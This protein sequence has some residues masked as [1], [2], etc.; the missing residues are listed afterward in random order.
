MVAVT[1][2]LLLGAP[3]A[4]THEG[5]AF[6]C[7]AFGDIPY[8]VTHSPTHVR[9]LAW[10]EFHC[11]SA[12]TLSVQVC[13]ARVPAG[14]DP[15]P[16]WCTYSRIEVAAGHKVFVRT[17]AHACAQTARYVSYVR[18]LGHPWDRGPAGICR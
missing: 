16:I 14:L 12:G 7:R 3:P 10:G 11:T 2:A 17:R 1:C 18:I 9:M 8:V 4:A 15:K 5:K 6:D 13:A